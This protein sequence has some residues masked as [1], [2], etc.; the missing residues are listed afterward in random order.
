MCKQGTKRQGKGNIDRNRK[1]KDIYRELFLDIFPICVKNP[2][3]RV[4]QK[5]G[6]KVIDIVL[7]MVYIIGVIGEK[8]FIHML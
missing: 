7:A 2:K 8:H 5:N 6:L 3:N 4:F 1:G